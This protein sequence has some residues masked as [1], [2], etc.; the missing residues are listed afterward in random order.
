MRILSLIIFFLFI[1][2]VFSKTYLVNSDHSY[3]KFQIGYMKVSKVYG[4]FKKFKGA[5]DFDEN[6]LLVSQ[7]EFE[8]DSN[9]LDTNDSKRDQHLRES[10]FFYVNKFPHIS[11]KLGEA[12]LSLNSPKKIEGKMFFK[13]KTYPLQFKAIYKG[14]QEDPWNKDKHSFFL[15]AETSLNR[16]DLG[17]TWNKKMDRGGWVLGEEV[18]VSLTIE[19]QES[20]FRPAFSRFRLPEK[21]KRSNEVVF[22]ETDKKKEKKEPTAKDEITK[23]ERPSSSKEMTGTDAIL[24]YLIGLPLLFIFILISVI[25][26]QRSLKYLNNMLHPLAAEIVADLLMV[27]FLIITTFYFAGFLGYGPHPLSKFF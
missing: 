23:N 6:S 11:F 27:G 19:A 22:P 1:S 5:F 15:T 16:K 24:T 3:V 9:S 17:L 21:R 4:S 20:S 12:K 10:D 7:V 25:I 14:L 18:I 8:I 2:P 26:R 13:G